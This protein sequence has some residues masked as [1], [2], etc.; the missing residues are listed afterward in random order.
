MSPL[1]LQIFYLFFPSFSSLENLW[2]LN[3]RQYKREYFWYRMCH[4]LCRNIF[5]RQTLP[6]LY[7]LCL[8][9]FV[10]PGIN[11]NITEI[12]NATKYPCTTIWKFSYEYEYQR[13]LSQCHIPQLHLSYLKCDME[14]WRKESSTA[15]F[16]EVT[17]N[18]TSMGVRRSHVPPSPTP[19]H[20]NYVCLVRLRANHNQIRVL[21]KA[22]FHA[23]LKDNLRS[24][25]WWMTRNIYIL[26]NSYTS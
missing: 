24:Y 3:E 21:W 26:M 10:F 6:Y 7:L 8:C 5:T 23:V 20:A 19:Y 25:C 18:M 16:I 4:H 22:C 2:S 12:C 13:D 17:L 1:A 11:N 14:G 9:L 15:R